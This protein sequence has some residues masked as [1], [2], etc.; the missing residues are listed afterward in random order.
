MNDVTWEISKRIIFEQRYQSLKGNSAFISRFRADGRRTGRSLRSFIISNYI[1]SVFSFSLLSVALTFVRLINNYSTDLPELELLLYFYVFSANIFNTIF[2]LD[3]LV[4]ENILQPLAALPLE[5]PQ[6]ILPIS[7]MLY[8]GSSS[9][10]VVTPFLLLEFLS[11]HSLLMLITGLLWMA[12]YIFLGYIAGSLI[13]HYLYRFRNPSRPSVMKN[14]GTL[15][16]VFVIVLIF[17]FF[18][19]WVYDP[20]ILPA[21][22]LPASQNALF[23][24]IPVINTPMLVRQSLTGFGFLLDGSAFFLFASVTALIYIGTHRLLFERILIPREG[25]MKHGENSSYRAGNVRMALFMK[26]LRII[27]RKSQYSLMLFF[28]VMVAIPFAVPLILSNASSSSFNPLGL[29]YALLTIPVVCAS[30][31][32]LLSFVSEGGAISI[33]FILPGSTRANVISKSFVGVVIFSCIVFPLTLLIMGAGRY[34]AV[35]FLLVPLNLIAGFSFSYL[36]L[37]KRLSRKLSP[38]ITVVNIDT[39]GGSFGLLV[40]FGFVLVQMLT[41]V[42]AGAVITMFAFPS[43]GRSFTLAVD[44]ALNLILL[45][46][47]IFMVSREKDW[48]SRKRLSSSGNADLQ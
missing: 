16:R 43:G 17:S 31:Y 46:Y 41:P 45:L 9:T 3:G 44:L 27:V 5:N 15:F 48:V 25:G 22:F 10:F 38:Y 4:S 30:I 40:S 23:S 18:E 12:V 33:M 47:S 36:N 28:P 35:D 26:N 24:L 20:Q 29:Y 34:T 7:Y 6:S 19:V 1:A 2:F 8:Y 14:M 39:F 32:S 11:N 21:T 37:L 13:F 42:I